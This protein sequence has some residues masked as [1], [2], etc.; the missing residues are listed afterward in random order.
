MDRVSRGNSEAFHALHFDLDVH[1][2]RRLRGYLEA[3]GSRYSTYHVPTPVARV[4]SNI[5]SMGDK[6]HCL[7]PGHVRLKG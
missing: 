2:M 3:R 1:T 5:M 4:A 6:Y 7:R